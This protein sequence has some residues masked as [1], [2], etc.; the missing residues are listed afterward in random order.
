MQ[1]SSDHCPPALRGKRSVKEENNKGE[2]DVISQHLT[3]FDID[4]PISKFE[5]NVRDT[6]RYTL[7]A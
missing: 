1:R 3:V 5:G 4:E 7:S 6:L 2:V